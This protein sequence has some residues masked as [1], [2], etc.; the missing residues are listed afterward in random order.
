[1]IDSADKKRFEETGL[2]RLD[3]INLWQSQLLIFFLKSMVK[4]IYTSSI[5]PK[6]VFTC[7]NVH[8]LDMFCL[9]AQLK[10]PSAQIK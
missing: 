9:E 10:Q 3:R 8:R 4:Y 7:C 1:V 6:I 2:V 5:L